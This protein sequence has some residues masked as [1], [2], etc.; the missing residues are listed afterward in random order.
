MQES[1][2]AKDSDHRL[3]SR[4]GYPQ[5]GGHDPVD[6][7][8]AAIP[9]HAQLLVAHASEGVQIAHGHA[10]RDE[11]RAA[12][13]HRIEN[14]PCHLPLES[15]ATECATDG[16]G[17]RVFDCRPEAGPTALARD[18]AGPLRQAIEGV[19]SVAA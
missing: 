17:G 6:A 5:R 8:R 1:D 16:A 4:R 3:A 19:S 10:V 12:G 15:S 18:G 2:V 9:K 7:A 11:H 14:V 13:G